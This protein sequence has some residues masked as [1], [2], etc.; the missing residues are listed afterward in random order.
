MWQTHCYSF[1]LG[2]F[3]Q[4]TQLVSLGLAYSWSYHMIPICSWRFGGYRLFS[5]EANGCSTSEESSSSSKLFRFPWKMHVLSLVQP[6]KTYS[7]RFVCAGPLKLY[8]NM[9]KS[10]Q[11]EWIPQSFRICKMISVLEMASWDL[12]RSIGLC[13]MLVIATMLYWIHRS[14]FQPFSTTSARKTAVIAQ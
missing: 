11:T 2:W 9:L 1:H 12:P 4:P 10:L 14:T 3:M 6:H 13:G 5:D 7:K 8:W